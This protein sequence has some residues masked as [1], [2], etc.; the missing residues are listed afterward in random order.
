[1][2]ITQHLQRNALHNPDC[3]STI[4]GDRVRNWGETRERVARLAGA[5]R[6]LGIASGESVA[7]LS[8]NSDRYLEYLF[9]VPWADAVVNPVNI[10]WSPGEIA[11][12]LLDSHTSMLFVDDAFAPMLPALRAEVPGLRT[13]VH[14]GD[15]PTPEGMLDYERLIA[16]H[17]PVDDARRSGEALAGIFYTGGTTGHPKG[18]M[19]SHANLVVSAMAAAAAGEFLEADGRTLHAAPMFHLADLFTVLIRNILG[20]THVI[21]P[22]FDPA[23]V[24]QAIEKHQVTDTLLVPTMIQMLIDAPG[25]DDADLRS[26]R[27]LIYGAS[28][29]SD[30]LLSRAAV[31]LPGVRF[32]QAYGMTE[33]APMATFLRPEEHADPVLRRS[34]GRA[35][36][37]VEVRIVDTDDN[38]VASGVVGEVVVRGGNVML[39]YWNRPA[40]TADALRGGWMHTG[41]GG[42]MDERGYVFLVDRIK[43][44]IVSGAENVYSAEV[45]NALATHPAVA[46]CAVI[47]VPDPELGERVHAVVVLFPGAAATHEELRAHCKTL[48]AGYKAPRTSEFVEAMPLSGA[49]K[50]LKRE[51]RAKYWPAAGRGIG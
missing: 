15:G 51:L 1:M 23:T 25:V 49:G 45:E 50:I 10:R 33:L 21:V 44:M 46:Q 32:T 28:P 36:P 4:F 22:F 11:Y 19:L 29:I 9:A 37:N 42:Y 6:S 17:P 48:I 3:E 34:A 38:E 7:I 40:E 47:G 13:V 8:L 2:N 12:S 43:D 35:G 39:G 26:L 31:A 24:A 16:E 27:R 18:V 14:C 41:D 30:A 20:G 5:L